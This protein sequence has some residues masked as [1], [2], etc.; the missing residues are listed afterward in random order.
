MSERRKPDD[1]VAL[2]N[3]RSSLIEHVLLEH[4]KQCLQGEDVVDHQLL[5]QYP[6]LMPEPSERLQVFQEMADLRAVL[7]VILSADGKT[8]F[9]ATH[10]S[11][12]ARWDTET[13]K[14]KVT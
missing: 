11:R 13:L 3:H 2:R 5:A 7:S 6:E 14:Q 1:S 9:I 10:D 12:L 8:A 4:F